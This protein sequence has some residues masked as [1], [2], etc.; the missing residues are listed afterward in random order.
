[1][2]EQLL[3]VVDLRHLSS[4]LTV[5]EAV[6][7]SVV[8]L[9]VAW[10]K[11]STESRLKLS[12]ASATHTKANRACRGSLTLRVGDATTFNAWFGAYLTG[13]KDAIRIAEERF[14]PDTRGLRC[15]DGDASVH[16]PARAP[17]GRRACLST[18]RGERPSLAPSTQR[19]TL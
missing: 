3:R 16:E 15:M 10:S 6:V 19:R 1:V 5:V 17:P 7:L 9:L 12:E 13:D 14:R 11:W 18:S 4:L 2:L 8:T